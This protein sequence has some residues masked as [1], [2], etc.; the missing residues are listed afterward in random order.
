MPR[1]IQNFECEG[2]CT[3]GIYQVLLAS[4]ESE[5]LFGIA[6]VELVVPKMVTVTGS[7]PADRS[8]SVQLPS[9][10]IDGSCRLNI[11]QKRQSRLNSL[12]KWRVF[13]V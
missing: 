5:V 10:M 3:F 13:S 4:F 12:S 2:Q 9:R 1:S 11:C 7:L 6:N 8:N